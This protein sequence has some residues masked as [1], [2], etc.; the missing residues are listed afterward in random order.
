MWEQ[1][2]QTGDGGANALIAPQQRALKTVGMAST[3]VDTPGAH[4]TRGAL[5]TRVSVLWLASQQLD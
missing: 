2:L 3:P 5:C 1:M 4:L